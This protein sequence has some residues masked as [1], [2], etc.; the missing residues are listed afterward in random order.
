MRLFLDAS[1]RAFVGVAPDGAVFLSDL[2]SSGTLEMDV[3]DD[4]W[5]AIYYPAWLS[6]QDL[7]QDLVVNEDGSTN[8]VAK[9]LAPVDEGIVSLRSFPSDSATDADRDDSLRALIKIIRHLLK[10]Q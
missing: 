8:M 7:S 10:K 2:L 1:S 4:D 5:Q 6:A 3:S 9:T